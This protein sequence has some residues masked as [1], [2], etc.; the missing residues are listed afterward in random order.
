MLESTV[1][2]K[3][4]K[5]SPYIA[6]LIKKKPDNGKENKGG[7]KKANE[8]QL[9]EVAKVS[10]SGLT[11]SSS[12][13]L[14]LENLHDSIEKAFEEFGVSRA[15]TTSGMKSKIDKD[16]NKL[17]YSRLD[18]QEKANF[19]N[20]STLKY[21]HNSTSS[22]PA[23]PPISSLNT[24]S[25]MKATKER[26]I[27]SATKLPQI[28]LRGNL[29]RDDENELSTGALNILDNNLKVVNV[30]GASVKAEGESLFDHFQK[31]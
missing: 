22:S 6:H 11:A 21:G 31:Y 19:L 27:P 3:P 15:E 30:E 7:N 13:K 10:T 25:N 9:S 20:A 26:N 12:P 1:P 28:N 29:N 24:S 4:L 17:S 8:V 5:P 16:S 14:A 18:T 23:L 2:P